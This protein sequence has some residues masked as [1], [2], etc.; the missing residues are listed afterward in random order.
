MWFPLKVYFLPWVCSLG[1]CPT[2]RLVYLQ[3]LPCIVIYAYSNDVS[4]KLLFK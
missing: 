1:S 4:L 2:G 3:E